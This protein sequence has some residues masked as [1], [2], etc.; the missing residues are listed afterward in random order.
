MTAELI[1][2]EKDI[3]HAYSLKNETQKQI[4][5]RYGLTQT[6]IGYIVNRKSWGHIE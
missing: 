3:R 2:F 6:H 4:G 5:D 1:G